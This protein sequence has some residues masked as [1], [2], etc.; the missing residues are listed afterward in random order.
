M[1][2]FVTGATGFIGRRLVD[3]LLHSGAGV[4]AL[5][6]GGDHDLPAG[7]EAVRGDILDPASLGDAGRGCDRLY[8]LAAL[9]TFD[10]ARR[11]QLLEVNG[12]GTRLVLEAAARWGIARSVVVSSA[13]TLGIARRP[14]VVL[15][16]ES[17]PAGETVGANPYLASKL[18]AEEEALR[19]A[20]RAPVVI[21]NPT[22]VY[23]AGDRT[24][25][26]GSLVTLIARL[27]LLP[28][29]PGGSNVVDVDDVAAGIVAAGERG[30]PGTRYVLGGENLPFAQ[31]FRLVARALGRR[32]PLVPLPRWT[33][34]PGRLGIRVAGLL[35]GNRFLTPQILDDL[36]AYKYYASGR[37]ERELGWRALVPFPECLARAVAYYREHGLLAPG[38]PAA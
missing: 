23:G 11:A 38:R 10:P 33:A 2:A 3:R 37:A 4:V 8:H 29:P 24:L 22:T 26:S 14:G 25:N 17:R 32:P 5:V 21:V 35:T 6:R 15:D 28:A 36:Y 34:A 12:T 1:R 7:V 18:A 19:A 31:I 30:R 20:A 16:E 9:I 13:C 27:P